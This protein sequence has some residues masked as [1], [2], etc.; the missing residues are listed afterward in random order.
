MWEQKC[1]F[2]GKTIRKVKNLVKAPDSDI[3]VCGV[4]IKIAV[5]LTGDNNDKKAGGTDLGC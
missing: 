5:D 4:C 3:Y 2:C 1:S